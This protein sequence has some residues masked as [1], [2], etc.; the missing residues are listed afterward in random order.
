MGDLQLG[1]FLLN[2]EGNK[3]KVTSITRAFDLPEDPECEIV[4]EVRLQQVNVYGKPTEELD[5]PYGRYTSFSPVVA[6]TIFYQGCLESKTPVL[7][8]NRRRLGW[9]P[10]DDIPRSDSRFY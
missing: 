8:V 3:F 10:S 1:M 2:P 4:S 5:T 7:L 9:N 6:M